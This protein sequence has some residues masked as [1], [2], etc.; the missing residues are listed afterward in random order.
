MKEVIS[1]AT[2]AV[3]VAENHWDK[4]GLAWYLPW[5][6]HTPIATWT[7]S[8]KGAAGAAAAAEDPKLKTPISWKICE[9]ITKIKN[10]AMKKTT[11]PLWVGRKVIGNWDNNM[12]RIPQWKEI[13][14]KTKTRVRRKKINLEE[15]D[16]ENHSQESVWPKLNHRSIVVWDR[17][18]IIELTKSMSSTR[19]RVVMMHVKVSKDKHIS[20]W[21]DWENLISVRWNSINKCAQS[22]EQWWVWKN[23]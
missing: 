5:G 12:I 18:I 15:C 10:C 1:R 20:R 21:V 4:W 16:C 11:P 7:Y 22:S 13:H 14:W 3:K 8:W 9:I 17:K 6:G 19:I 2:G 23:K